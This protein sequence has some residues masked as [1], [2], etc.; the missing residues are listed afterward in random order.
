MS[1]LN[2]MLNR[3][4]LR[5]G[6]HWTERKTD[7]A[8]ENYWAG[9]AIRNTLNAIS[10]RLAAKLPFAREDDGANGIKNIVY[11][12]GARKGLQRF[13][14]SKVKNAAQESSTAET[15]GEGL[16]MIGHALKDIDVYM[17]HS[18][19]IPEAD[20]AL[21]Q[22]FKSELETALAAAKSSGAVISSVGERPG[23]MGRLKNM[24]GLGGNRAAYVGQNALDNLKGGIEKLPEDS[25]LRNLFYQNEE[26]LSKYA[27]QS[28]K[29]DLTLL[30]RAESTV[31]KMG[32]K[33][34]WL[35]ASGVGI[36]AELVGKMKYLPVL[37]GAMVMIPLATAVVTGNPQAISS[38]I[39]EQAGSYVGGALGMTMTSGA[40][41]TAAAGGAAAG[42]MAT[43]PAFLVV[44]GMTVGV[45]LLGAVVFGQLGKSAN[46]NVLTGAIGNAARGAVNFGSN[47][48][49]GMGDVIPENAPE[50]VKEQASHL[51]GRRLAGKFFGNHH[52]VAPNGEI[53]PPLPVA[54]NEPSNANSEWF[55]DN[56]GTLVQVTKKEHEHV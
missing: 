40:M 15:A 20:K 49:L 52:E 56:T 47:K 50:K 29:Q 55:V 28:A 1:V 3:E 31:A 33:G 53:V 4:I 12:F 23:L 10:P 38:I 22:T 9:D 30:G 35:K 41:A 54:N 36:G 18:A 13:I 19:N 17:A 11:G 43:L 21:L 37:G 6:F 42:V 34:R 39:G 32:G 45:G 2:F 48:L 27:M 46:F 51:M 5:C 25:K 24:I 14:P 44:G 8:T 26:V 7:V 16:K